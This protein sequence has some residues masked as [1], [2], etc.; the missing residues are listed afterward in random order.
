MNWPNGFPPDSDRDRERERGSK[1]G[2]GSKTVALELK[3]QF[4]AINYR[5]FIYVHIC[6]RMTRL[7]IIIMIMPGVFRVNKTQSTIVSQYI[8][9][10]NIAR[11]GNECANVPIL[12]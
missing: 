2:R 12:H 3:Q 4:S 10:V 1:R 11:V 9:T 5:F 6:S 8:F 7:G